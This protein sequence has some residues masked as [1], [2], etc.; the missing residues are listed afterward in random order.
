MRCALDE[1]AQQL[2]SAEQIIVIDVAPKGHVIL[3]EGDEARPHSRL[4]IRNIVI[5]R[6]RPL[7]D[8]VEA[9]LAELGAQLSGEVVILLGASGLDLERSLSPSEAR[10]K[11]R[12]WVRNSRTRG[13]FGLWRLRCQ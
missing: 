10:T 9:L 2:M 6:E 11:L 8:V 5:L 4:T 12:T 1:A 13:I 7:D 3:H